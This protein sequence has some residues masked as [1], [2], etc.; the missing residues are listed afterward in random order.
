[1]SESE[2]K[3]VSS[4][5]LLDRIVMAVELIA[6]RRPNKVRSIG[7]ESLLHKEIDLTQ[8]YTSQVDGNF[9][10]IGRLGPKFA[11]IVGHLY[12]LYTIHMDGKSATVADFSTPRSVSR[13]F[14]LTLAKIRL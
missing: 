2:L 8:V 14:A 6:N 4:D 12:H 5:G 9:L 1:M 3:L 10:T 7:V 11:D 13:G